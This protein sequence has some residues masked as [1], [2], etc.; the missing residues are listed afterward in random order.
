MKIMNVFIT[1]LWFMVDTATFN[2]EKG[3]KTGKEEI[4]SHFTSRQ[5]YGF[6]LI[7][8][9]AWSDESLNKGQN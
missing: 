9:D 1:T 7:L 8:N 5:L 4:S 2:K 6:P 3:K